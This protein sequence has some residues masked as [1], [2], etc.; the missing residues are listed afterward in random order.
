M[1]FNFEASETNDF[2]GVA[3]NIVTQFHNSIFFD[4]IKFFLTPNEKRKILG[5]E[6]LQG[7]EVLNRPVP[8]QPG[9]VKK[10]SL[11]PCRKH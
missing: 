10:K 2:V 5:F 4:L 8:V 7:G 3:T 6:P 9:E 11:K 1:T